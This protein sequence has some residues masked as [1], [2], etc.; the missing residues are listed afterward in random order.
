MTDNNNFE[1][2]EHVEGDHHEEI[3]AAPAG[4]RSNLGSAWRSQP[5]FKLFVLIIVVGA[6]VA[7]AVSLFS[8]SNSKSAVGLLKPP[9]MHEAP[10]GK[11]SPYLKEQTEMANKQR[12]DEA[13]QSGGS[14][15]PTPIGP[16]TDNGELAPAVPK[17][18]PLNEL[19]AEVENMNKQLQEAKQAAA[20]PPPQ[21]AA[22]EP[23]DDTLAQAMQRQMGQ[24]L[25]S[26]V[27][28]GNKQVAVY[29]LDTL[30]R[31]RQEAEKAATGGDASKTEG[32]TPPAKTMVSAG[33]VSYAQLLTEANSDVPG[34]ILAQIVSGP[35]KGARVVGQFVVANGYSDYLTLTFKLANWHGTDYRINALALDPDTTLGGMATEVDQRYM[36]RLI[37]PAAAGFLQGFSSAIG[38]GNSSISTNGTTTIVDQ[39]GKGTR[40]GIY[41][42]IGAAASTASQF[43]QTQANNTKPLVRVAAGTPMGL[44]F[45]DT[46]TDAPIT[47]GQTAQ[48]MPYGQ[49]PYNGNYQY[50]QT[51][52]SYGQN[53][54]Q[55]YG[56][57]GYNA[58]GYPVMYQNSGYQNQQSVGGFGVSQQPYAPNSTVFYTH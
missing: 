36:T 16:G 25:D 12:T 6:V 33:T 49:T 31:E 4:L 24:M 51:P 20:A 14:A 45:V 52:S 19:R 38:Q 34:P 47:A 3:A 26:W 23:F 48:N 58:G 39:S 53:Y 7:V 44:F 13:I 37:L 50:G 15:L 42:G 17:E 5:L 27:P 56:N 18:D 11:S 43:F 32:T 57:S 2:F 28:K 55:N 1:E 22:P 9:D 21:Q 30:A 35:L 10:G 46:V 40:Q 29:D 54:G 8:G 41:T